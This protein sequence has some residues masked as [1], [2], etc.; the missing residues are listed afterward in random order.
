MK[1]Q[2]LESRIQRCAEDYGDPRL[3][4][5]ANEAAELEKAC[6]RLRQKF[7]VLSLLYWLLVGLSVGTC[8]VQIAIRMGWL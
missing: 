2:S 7:R 6:D 5:Y 4:V 1:T 3:R 8:C